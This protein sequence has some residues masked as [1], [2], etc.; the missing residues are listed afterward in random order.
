MGVKIDIKK[1]L[2]LADKMR[3]TEMPYTEIEKE[4][5]VLQEI[6]FL[7]YKAQQKQLFCAVCDTYVDIEIRLVEQEINGVITPQIEVYC[8]EC[9]ELVYWVDAEITNETIVEKM[10]D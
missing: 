1:I 10:E 7:K 6:G 5:G 3:I 9:G 4:M 2:E 8:K